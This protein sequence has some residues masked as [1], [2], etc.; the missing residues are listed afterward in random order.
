MDSF[1]EIFADALQKETDEVKPE[2]KFR[3][4]PEWDSIAMLSV[5]AAINSEYDLVIPRTAYDKLIT[6]SDIYN[7]VQSNQ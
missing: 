3:D 2:D 5:G 7:F 1:L 6:V 4:Y